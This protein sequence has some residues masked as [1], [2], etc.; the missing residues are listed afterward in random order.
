MNRPKVYNLRFSDE[1][2]AKLKAYAES[3]QITPAE[4]L[5]DYIKRLPKPL[6]K[7]LL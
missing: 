1:E 4:I 6:E 7:P 2:W 3:K 5:R